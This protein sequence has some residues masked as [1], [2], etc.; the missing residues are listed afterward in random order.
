M[1]IHR[2]SIGGHA[3]TQA[4]NGATA[5]TPGPQ[6]GHR[7]HTSR[8]GNGATAGRPRGLKPENQ[9]G[10][11][12][13]SGGFPMDEAGTPASRIRRATSH[14]CHARHEHETR[15]SGCGDQCW[16]HPPISDAKQKSSPRLFA[17]E[18]PEHT[19]MVLENNRFC[20]VC[21]GT[22][23][24][25]SAGLAGSD[26]LPS[27]KVLTIGSYPQGGHRCVIIDRIRACARSRAR[28]APRG[29]ENQNPPD[30]QR[31]HQTPDRMCVDNDSCRM[32]N[33]GP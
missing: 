5:G 21:S 26:V 4:G 18:C 10:H 29:N 33:I 24:T 7:R 31:K 32:P 14:A 1:R 19:P 20:C 15:L 23:A 6:P 22:F 30:P 8:D 3:G 25:T 9:R 28:K 17:D 11:N 13:D 27:C 12:L 16:T 2:G